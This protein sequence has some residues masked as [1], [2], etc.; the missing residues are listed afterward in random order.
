MLTKL[1]RLFANKNKKELEDAEEDFD[2]LMD[3]LDGDQVYLEKLER[4]VQ[5]E[6]EEIDGD[7]TE[8]S[9]EVDEAVE[10]KT[11]AKVK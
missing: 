6:F 5:E 3:T 1:K 11:P 8:I 4:H 10:E 9:K 7:I 2:E